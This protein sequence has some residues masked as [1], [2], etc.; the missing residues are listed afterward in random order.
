MNIIAT[1]ESRYN[2]LTK[3]EKK[4]AE[5]I[6]AHPQTI[7]NLSIED[8]S[9]RLNVATAT[10]TRFVKKI[11]CRN[12]VDLKLRLREISSSEIGDDEHLF[13]QIHNYYS[14]VLQGTTH[15][16]DEADIQQMVDQIL[17]AERIIIN[18]VGSS[19]LSAKEFQ[20]RLYRMGLDA[21]VNADAHMI[22]MSGEVARPGELMIGISHSGETYEVTHALSQAIA[23]GAYGLAI[24]SSQG[25]SLDQVDSCYSIYVH[26]SKF[27]ST[28]EFINSQV[29]LMYLIDL[30]SMRLM[31]E[32]AL[33][34]RYHATRETIIQCREGKR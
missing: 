30:L 29:S 34:A 31:E 13:S 32:P 6:V 16:I 22:L 11:D 3:K 8:L 2:Q 9:D 18:G 24:T 28:E 21:V 23:K 10:I 7:S 19:G 25:S 12:F 5:Y 14:R 20:M 17:S 15:L 1:I 4:I 26:N 33:K 27:A